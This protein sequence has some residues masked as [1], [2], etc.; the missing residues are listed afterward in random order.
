MTGSNHDLLE[1]DGGQERSDRVL[2][3]LARHDA[4]TDGLVRSMHKRMQH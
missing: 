3:N 2:H 1:A 4:I